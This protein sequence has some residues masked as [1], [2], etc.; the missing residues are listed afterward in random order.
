MHKWIVILTMFL[1]GC[2]TT[3]TTKTGKHQGK[4]KAAE[5]RA[6][7]VVAQPA[8]APPEHECALTFIAADAEA[9]SRALAGSASGDCRLDTVTID[10]SKVTVTWKSGSGQLQ[11]MLAPFACSR[12]MTTE[13]V[14]TNAYLSTWTGSRGGCSDTADAVSALVSGG[15]LPAAR[16]APSA[17]TLNMPAST[18]TAP[19]GATP[20]R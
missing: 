8:Q 20:S 1:F 14:A 2:A 7:G 3:A 19:P 9:F 18:V 16:L 6:S 15:R 5:P 17:A 10:K 12:P 11:L 13:P 4:G